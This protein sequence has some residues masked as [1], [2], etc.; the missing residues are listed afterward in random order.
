MN[1]P[2]LTTL[3]VAA[4]IAATP[5]TATTALIPIPITSNW[6]Q[7]TL[8]GDPHI[9]RGVK[10]L[11]SRFNAFLKIYEAKG[12]EKALKSQELKLLEEAMASLNERIAALGDGSVRQGDGSVKLSDEVIQKMRLDLQQMMETVGK[13]L[14]D[15]KI[16]PN[17]S[18]A[19]G[20]A[21]TLKINIQRLM[22]SYAK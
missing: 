20:S 5:A 3:T 8:W 22:D 15:L 2:I 14:G 10:L 19:D 11:Q 1:K 12:L 9:Q 16:A 7:S 4:A 6:T 17:K 13:S 21:R 18:A